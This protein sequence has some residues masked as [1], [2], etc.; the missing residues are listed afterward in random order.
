MQDNKHERE[1]TIRFVQTHAKK[2]ETAQAA[3]DAS[4]DHEKAARELEEYLVSQDATAT[5]TYA[6]VGRV[7][8]NKPRL[9]ASVTQPNF[10]K[11]KQHLLS[12]GRDDLVRETI[13]PQ[14]L[15]SYVKSLVEEGQEP[16]DGVSYCLKSQLK[17]Y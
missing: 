4:A 8:I 10:E 9:Y 6:G 11:V 15:S 12:I 2:A 7:Q 3:K 14:Q 13:N 17:I 1:L 16:P 5:S